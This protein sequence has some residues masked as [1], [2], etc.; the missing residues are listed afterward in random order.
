MHILAFD[1]Q[2]SVFYP[3]FESQLG[4][5]NQFSSF[6]QVAQGSCQS[7]SG[8][9]QNLITIKSIKKSVDLTSLAEGSSN[10]VPSVARL[11][12]VLSFVILNQNLD[13]AMAFIQVI[14]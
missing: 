12:I 8:L 11:S 4:Q 7:K 14:C 2:L 6:I 5:R 10:I 13:G 3:N 9:N 1:F